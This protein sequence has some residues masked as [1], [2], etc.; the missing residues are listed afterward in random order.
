MWWKT[1]LIKKTVRVVTNDKFSHNAYIIGSNVPQNF[2][3]VMVLL[4]RSRNKLHCLGMK[5][6][7]KMRFDQIVQC[8]ILAVLY[9]FISC[10]FNSLAYYFSE[11]HYCGFADR[12]C[13]AW[14]LWSPSLWKLWSLSINVAF[15]CNYVRFSQFKCQMFNTIWGHT[16]VKISRRR[17]KNNLK[18]SGY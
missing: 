9:T 4:I 3:Y 11:L 13:N 6:Q 17:N 2:K 15:S 12:F 7:C 16:I 10:Y 18:K 8:F 14:C 1:S 5:A